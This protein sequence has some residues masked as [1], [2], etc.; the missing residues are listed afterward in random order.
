MGGTVP[1]VA[2]CFLSAGTNPPPPSGGSEE[3]KPK[4]RPWSI[5]SRLDP[6]LREG[7]DQGVALCGRWGNRIAKKN[8]HRHTPGGLLAVAKLA[9][10]APGIGA[11]PI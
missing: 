4:P 1:W 6:R 8:Q 2:G 3:K 9:V 11:G 5:V 10:L 7:D